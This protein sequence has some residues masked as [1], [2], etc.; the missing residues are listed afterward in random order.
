MHN[1]AVN[2]LTK[3][4][5]AKPVTA[6]EIEGFTEMCKIL[7]ICDCG[8]YTSMAVTRKEAN[9][10]RHRNYPSF[11]QSYAMPVGFGK[12]AIRPRQPG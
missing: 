11:N 4:K 6:E 12:R 8:A 10:S 5:E 7:Q 3:F 9:E 2:A 1:L